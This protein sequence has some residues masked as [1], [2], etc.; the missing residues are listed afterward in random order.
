MFRGTLRESILIAALI[1]VVLLASATPALA[2]DRLIQGTV[3]TDQGD[4]VAEATI[5]VTRRSDFF[6]LDQSR[7]G[8]GWGETW[9]GSTNGKGEY[10]VRVPTAGVYL[11]TASK[12]NSRSDEVEAVVQDDRRTAVNLTLWKTGAARGPETGCGDPKAIKAFEESDLTANVKGSAVVGLLRWLEAVQWHTPGCADPPAMEVV[13]YS[14]E[15]L[16]TLSSGLKQL[17]RQM[18]QSDPPAVIQ[19]YDRQF[20][21]EVIERI[22]HG[23]ATLRRGAVLHADI[24]VIVPGSLAQSIRVDDGRQTGSGRHGT[25]HWEMGRLLLDLV[26]PRPG[27]DAGA[28]LWYRAVSAHMLRE[29]W[30]VDASEHLER[31]RQVFPDRPVFLIDAAY[32][33]EELSS[34][35][36]QAAAQQLRADRTRTAIDSRR[37]ELQRAERFLKDAMAVALAPHTGTTTSEEIPSIRVRLGHVLEE[38]GRHEEAAGNLRLAL[39]AELNRERQYLA[40]LFLGRAEQALGRRDEAKRRYA[41]AA[42][43]FPNAQSPH[44]ALSQ[45][46]HQSGDQAEALRALERLKSYSSSDVHRADPWWLY[47]YPHLEDAEDLMNEMR[48]LGGSVVE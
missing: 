29:G 2:Q 38:L 9:R 15:E 12:V 4:P 39:E 34:P 11:V 8:T 43:L 37:S 46:A 1:K 32:L 44:L 28:L 7:R 3:V 42:A 14:Q 16:A 10:L 35:A 40:E 24:A 41:H 17:R 33:H 18:D 23:N 20:A 19:L 45:L 21:R 6:G 27:S 22:F 36:I 30:L 26:T 31:A 47:Y 13:S 48:K 5:E 25:L